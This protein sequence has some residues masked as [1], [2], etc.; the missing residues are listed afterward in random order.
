MVSDAYGY[1][2]ST[3]WGSLNLQVVDSSCLNT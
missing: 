1:G 3:Y 2:N